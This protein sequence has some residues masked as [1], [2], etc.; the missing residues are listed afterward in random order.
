MK[1]KFTQIY[2]RNN[3][4]KQSRHVLLHQSQW[5]PSVTSGHKALLTD[6]LRVPAVSKM[7]SQSRAR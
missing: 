6:A 1:I 2:M 7:P 5:M 4:P 3:V